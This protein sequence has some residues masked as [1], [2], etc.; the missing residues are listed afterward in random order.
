MG[1][2]ER[3]T[4]RI[5]AGAQPA[6]I[7]ARAEFGVPYLFQSIVSASASAVWITLEEGD[8]AV[9]LGNKLSRAVRR[10][11]GATMF[12]AGMPYAYGLNYLVGLTEELGPLA[13]FVDEAQHCPSFCAVAVLAAERS[14]HR[15]KVVLAGHGASTD[16]RSFLQQSGPPLLT[17]VDLAVA[18]DE[19]R[20][21]LAS[22]G[23]DVDGSVERRVRDARGAYERIVMSRGASGCLRPTSETGIGQLPH[24]A[25]PSIED[26]KL[27][28]KWRAAFEAAV[29]RRSALALEVLD[30]AADQYFAQGELL[31]FL[32]F[33]SRLLETHPSHPHVLYWWFQAH[34]GL[35]THHEVEDRVANYLE[36]H[37]AQAPLLSAAYASVVRPT[38]ALERAE[39]AVKSMRGPETLATLGFLRAVNGNLP[40]GIQLLK[41]AYDGYRTARRYHKAIQVSNSIGSAYVQL[42]EYRQAL[43]WAQSSLEELRRRDIREELLRLST[44]NLV[45]Y[46]LLLIGDVEAG[47]EQ[48]KRIR[49]SLDSN[50][51]PTLEGLVSTFGDYALVRG[52]VAEALGFYERL[53]R[54]FASHLPGYSARY[55]VRGLLHVGRLDAARAVV[56]V[57]E[58]MLA[59]MDRTERI[60]LW[61]ASRLVQAMS[62][63]TTEP[64]LEDLL[65][66]PVMQSDAVM[67]AELILSVVGLKW[68]KGQLNEAATLVR[69]HTDVLS[70][71]GRSGWRLL[72]PPGTDVDALMRHLGAEVGS[73]TR[74]SVLGTRELVK[75]G[76][77]RDIS[78]RHGELLAILAMSVDGLSGEALLLEMYGERGR[79]S[80]LKATVSRARRIVAIESMPYRLSEAMYVDVVHLDDLLAAG[81]IREALELYKGPLLPESEA[82]GIRRARERI[83]EAV[84][85]AVLHAGEA[86]LALRLARKFPDDLEL[87]EKAKELTAKDDPAYPL[88]RA[89]IRRIRGE[90]GL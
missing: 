61:V 70:G 24:S 14:Q 42:G 75:R 44:V 82:P 18:V 32:H 50:I 23:V 38:D 30:R 10:V 90:W 85:Q 20:S 2:F 3:Q 68:R 88:I 39:R 73:S 74:L 48:L 57:A 83:D 62:D 33:V 89:R 26:L 65:G 47:E 66:E 55:Y 84:R 54:H 78:L 16:W 46:T 13:V 6:V 60:N 1:W 79:L 67:R 51:P 64:G 87:W 5:L 69:D 27:A 19:A 53:Y 40:S 43:V 8:D 86:D 9:A 7:D 80:T 25:E 63:N 49:L 41:E 45:A 4:E 21:M 12:G 52:G 11:F 56:T 59:S 77:S 72:A 22:A 36:S 34:A 76:S 28:G 31:Q 29:R 35:G 81:R 58:D 71:L 17:E 37:E 15:M